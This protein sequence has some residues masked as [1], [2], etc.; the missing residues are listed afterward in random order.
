MARQEDTCWRCGSEWAS[1]D[2]QRTTL[3][4]IP[5]DAHEQVEDAERWT[6]EGGYFAS[7]VTAPLTV[8]AARR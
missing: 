3:R 5:G 7:E 8:A 2:E 1:E 6:N 4:L